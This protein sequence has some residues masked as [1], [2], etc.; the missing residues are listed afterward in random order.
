MSYDSLNSIITFES[1]HEMRPKVARRL[2]LNFG[3]P[4]FFYVGLA[5]GHPPFFASNLLIIHSIFLVILTV[6]IVSPRSRLIMKL[7]FDDNQRMLNVFYN[8]YVFYDNTIS[9][10]YKNTSF[11]YRYKIFRRGDMP[12]TLEIFKSG[13]YIGEIREN[14]K[15]GWSK[16][17]LEAILGKLDLVNNH[18]IKIKT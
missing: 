16:E 17:E 1:K 14:N 7:E 11:K 9:I 6:K 4:M 15:I 18:Q 2:W 12:K 10:L 3:V 8:Q 13:K 5:V